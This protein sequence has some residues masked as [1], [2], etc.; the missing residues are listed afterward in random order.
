MP[1]ALLRLSILLCVSLQVACLDT[2]E[3]ELPGP[4]AD[5]H[6]TDIA[7]SGDADAAV[8]DAQPD[9][10]ADTSAEADSSTTDPTACGPYG[11]SCPDGYGCD[12]TTGHCTAPDGMLFVAAG[13]FFMGC[14]P[15]GDTDCTDNEAPVHQVDVPAFHID[16]RETT[17][18]E[19][20]D[21]VD[22][23]VC[24]APTLQ[25]DLAGGTCNFSAT[26]R[27][28]HPVNCL[29]QLQAQGYC[30]W[31]GAR[32]CTEAEWELAARGSCATVSGDCATSMRKYPWGDSTPSCTL[33]NYATCGDDTVAVGSHPSG[34]SVYGVE[35]MSGNVRE[36][37]QD[38]WHVS[39]DGAPN[40]GSAWLG[41]VYGVKRGGAFLSPAPDMRAT[42]RSLD[43]TLEPA[44]GGVR[45]CS[46]PASGGF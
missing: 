40:D 14:D 39:Y 44:S 33:A 34:A 12:A 17:A 15:A 35:D 42:T 4:D 31:R 3:G 9:A 36:W 29:I 28:D 27:G 26:G 11:L 16:R 23:G 1:N 5:A 45:C 6:G 41:G 20:A 37:V 19:Y 8:L 10:V 32:L 24:T 43:F 30:E 21:C 22:D 18:A 2:T 46:S 25:P 13:A 38:A 7:T